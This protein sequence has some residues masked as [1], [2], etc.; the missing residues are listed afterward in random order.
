MYEHPYQQA[1]LTEMRSA[2]PRYLNHIGR[3][4]SVIFKTHIQEYA[5]CALSRVFYIFVLHC[6]LLSPSTNCLSYVHR[7]DRPFAFLAQYIT[8]YSRWAQ[9]VLISEHIIYVPLENKSCY[10]RLHIM[11]LFHTKKTLLI[12]GL[13]H[14]D[15]LCTFQNVRHHHLN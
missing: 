8:P 15:R 3:D 14:Y 10:Q 11:Q 7:C 6:V 2:P 5:L 4:R 9:C 13:F 1:R 12:Q